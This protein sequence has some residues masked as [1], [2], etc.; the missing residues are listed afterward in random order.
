MN[1]TPSLRPL[2]GFG[3]LIVAF[4]LGASAAFAQDGAGSTEKQAY[5]Q[6][7]NFALTGGSAQVNALVLKKDRAQITLTGTVYFGEQVN[8]AITGAVFVGDGRFAVE[9]PNSEFEKENVKRLLGVDNIESDF[10]TAV[11]RF[12]DDTAALIGQAQ[13]GPANERAQKLALENDARLMRE[14]GANIPAR[15]AISLLNGEKPGFFLATFDGGRRDRFS[16]VLD[17]QNRIP[18]ANFDINAGE[19]GLIWA[20]NSAIYS[21]EVW[22]AFYGLDDYARGNVAYSDANDQIDIAHYRMDVDLRDYNDRLRVLSHITIEAL[23][24]NLRAVGF[25]IGESLSEYDNNRLKKQ[26][27]LKSAR[28][29]GT[30]LDVVQEDWE[31]GFTVFLPQ[32]LKPGDKLELDLD[33]EGD[34]IIDTDY[35]GECHYPRSNTTWYPRHGYLDRSTYDL[36]FRHPKKW[37]VASVGARTSEGPDVEDKDGAISKYEMK[38]PVALI[39]FAMGPFKRHNDSI[40][41]EKGGSPT[42][43]EFNSLPGDLAA[44]KEDFVLAELNNSVRF[45]T[46]MFGTYP[47]PSFGAAFHPF[48]FGQGFPSM[49]MIPKTDRASKYT[50]SFVAHETAHQWWGNIV[51]W[52]S[53]RDQWL[54][55]GFAEYSGILYT[56][57]RDGRGSKEDLLGELRSSLKNPPVTLTGV[58]KGRLVDVGPIIL[59]HRLNTSKTFGAYQTL[60]Y[61]KGALVLRMLHFMMS[62]PSNGDGQ[63]FY[64]MMTDFVERHRNKT[65][66]TDDFRAVVN[67][68]FAK[69]PI[70][71]KYGMNNLNWLF[72]QAVYKSE[73]PS[74]EMQ[75]KVITE[76]DGKVMLTGTV[77]QKNA[78]ENWVMVLPVKIGFGGD[79]SGMGTV[80]VQGASTPFKIPLPAAPSKV[81]LDPDRWILAE[82]VSVKGN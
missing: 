30:Q 26:M 65:A 73:L 49:L 31:G 7:R 16:L 77:T 38:E 53:Y 69:T 17:H 61:N 55:E 50:Y 18:V 42:P 57:L 46:A 79:K 35:C 19:K 11:F 51:A 14:T 82:T 1:K 80:I 66:S 21:P 60:I 54:S 48:P 24:P 47:Y 45:F 68:H 70:A 74:Y 43:L 62:N 37:K 81:Q 72:R 32:A 40:K 34:F 33:A 76:A 52:R 56:G 5:T 28:S 67:E 3:C 22:L 71:K 6:L 63:P 44:I 15:L 20:Y 39:V 58:G 4:T 25:K 8:G 23:Q 64:D 41:W 29:G 2:L 27:R 36:T 59:G 10:K 9:T 78:G 12:T 13:P 75:Y